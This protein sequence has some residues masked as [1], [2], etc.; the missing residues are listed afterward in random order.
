MEKNL[1]YLPYFS[2]S[3]FPQAGAPTGQFPTGSSSTNPFL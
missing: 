1:K 2:S 3:I